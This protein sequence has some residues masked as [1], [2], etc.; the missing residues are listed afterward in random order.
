MPEKK[1]VE[2]AVLAGG[3]GGY[4]FWIHKQKILYKSE[5]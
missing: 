5:L 4:I 2:I 1:Y 3:Y